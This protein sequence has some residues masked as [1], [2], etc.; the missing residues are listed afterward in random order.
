M[1]RG[2]Q[3]NSAKKQKLNEAF[4]ST[5]VEAF[6]NF[7]EKLEEVF[8]INNMDE[9]KKGKRELIQQAINTINFNSLKDPKLKFV[10]N[11]ES[12]GDAELYFRKQTQE[13]NNRAANCQR[14]IQRLKEQRNDIEN[15]P[16][17]GYMSSTND[18]TFEA[19]MDIVDRAHTPEDFKI[20][21]QKHLFLKKIIEFHD[22][23]TSKYG[24]CLVSEPELS[25]ITGMVL[26]PSLKHHN[27]LLE[28][29]IEYRKFR[30]EPANDV[31]IDNFCLEVVDT[32]RKKNHPTS[33]SQ[34]PSPFPSNAL[35]L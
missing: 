26:E 10:E 24:D 25:A 9:N 21:D 8:I 23:V 27:S 17:S 11:V 19:I 5:L 7:R 13:V 1:T 16:D 6:E 18:H 20:A 31:S 35:D 28:A 33:S 12:L 4:P 2:R 15:N 14:E 3:P 32:I 34:I 22:E 30:V 29:N